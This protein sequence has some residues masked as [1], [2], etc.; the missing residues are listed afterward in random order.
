MKL[1]CSD[2]AIASAN[3]SPA[4][5]IPNANFTHV[6][7]ETGDAFVKH[8]EEKVHAY[9]ANRNCQY[10]LE[11]IPELEAKLEELKE[12]RAGM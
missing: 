9:K 12:K 5:N 6:S 11:L 10:Y 7:E 8:V 3:I 1:Y 2:G 4:P